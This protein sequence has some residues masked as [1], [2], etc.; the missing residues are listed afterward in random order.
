MLGMEAGCATVP[1][2]NLTLLIQIQV[3]NGLSLV[4]RVK[5]E[6]TSR[7]CLPRTIMRRPLHPK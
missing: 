2:L 7:R 3:V 5:D 4:L 6:Q 1:H